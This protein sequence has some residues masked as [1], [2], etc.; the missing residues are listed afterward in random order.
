[1]HSNHRFVEW[2]SWGKRSH[3]GTQSIEHPSRIAKESDD[4][5]ILNRY[6]EFNEVP[7]IWSVVSIWPMCFPLTGDEGQG[8]DGV[9]VMLAVHLN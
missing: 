6:L 8:F 2:H 1:M 9:I 5:T 4:S 3:V 7:G